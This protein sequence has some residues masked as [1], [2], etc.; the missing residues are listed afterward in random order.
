MKLIDVLS[1][2]LKEPFDRLKRNLD[3]INYSIALGLRTFISIFIVC[4][5]EKVSNHIS[6]HSLVVG[7]F[8]TNY[9]ANN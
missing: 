1:N 4:L 7:L 5:E 9:T 8:Y 6:L 3:I 2:R